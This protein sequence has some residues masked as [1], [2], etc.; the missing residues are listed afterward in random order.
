MCMYMW[1]IIS[2]QKGMYYKKITVKAMPL[3]VI[4][5]HL[6]IV[7]RIV[8]KLSHQKKSYAQMASHKD[9]IRDRCT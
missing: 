9:M 4:D 6:V 8:Y 5:N 3:L 1:K 7:Y 2:V